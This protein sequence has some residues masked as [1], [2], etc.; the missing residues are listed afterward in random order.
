MTDGT[1]CAQASHCGA[2]PKPPQDVCPLKWDLLA[3]ALEHRAIDVRDE[4]EYPNPDFIAQVIIE[5]MR[6][7][8]EAV[9][10]LIRHAALR[11]TR[12][13]RSHA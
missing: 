8:N 3:R 11:V 9:I 7:G 13:A 1:V 12:P 4:F 2:K 6:T 5:D 10:R